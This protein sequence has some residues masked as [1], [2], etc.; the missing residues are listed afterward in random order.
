M[1]EAFL[2]D[3][4]LAFPI[5]TTFWIAYLCLEAA[6]IVQSKSSLDNMLLDEQEDDKSFKLQLMKLQELA[7]SAMRKI[8]E[9]SD[10]FKMLMNLQ[11]ISPDFFLYS[12][13]IKQRK[14]ALLSLIFVALENPKC[15]SD[16]YQLLI[17]SIRIQDNSLL[18][19]GDLHKQLAKDE[20]H[21]L[22]LLLPFFN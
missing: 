14:T 8:F 15:A 5:N 17:M 16:A 9:D 10:F 3:P 18:S 2:F 19:A 1:T 20:L 21:R 4:D 6:A 13:S 7:V 12:I 11:E 22:L